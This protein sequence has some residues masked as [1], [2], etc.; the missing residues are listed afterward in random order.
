MDLYGADGVVSGETDA[1]AQRTY[2]RMHPRQ[3]CRCRTCFICLSASKQVIDSLAEF[4]FSTTVNTSSKNKRKVIFFFC[5]I[6][7]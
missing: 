2:P 7:N 6:H 3:S 1:T 5:G 4:V